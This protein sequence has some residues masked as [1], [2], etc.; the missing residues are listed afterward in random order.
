MFSESRC[1]N[2]FGCHDHEPL[3]EKELAS[4]LGAAQRGCPYGDLEW[5]ESTV[6]RLGL[7]ST[8]R[9]RGRPRVRNRPRDNKNE[10]CTPFLGR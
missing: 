3:T 9:P 1:A 7:Q 6:A 4:V 2:V 10:S 8:L 5:V